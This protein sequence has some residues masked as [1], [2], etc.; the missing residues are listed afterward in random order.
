ME[1]AVVVVPLAP[2]G[3][4]WLARVNRIPTGTTS[5]E[6]PGG[7]IDRDDEDALSAGLRELE[8][9]CGLVASGGG[10]VLRNV[11]E[12]APGMGSF[13]HYVVV[14]RDV[15]PR[16]GRRPAPQADEG[17]LAVRCFDQFQVH[18]LM[19]RRAITVL[20]TLA[21]LIVS[22]WLDLGPLERRAVRRRA[23]TRIV[24]RSRRA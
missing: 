3:K 6:L 4:L 7:A 21:A 11:L 22:G 16:V 2:D 18:R 13:P 15:V 20:S 5:W 1:P 14:V 8:E 9:E 10:R 12:L 24:R 19:K 17:I 23:G